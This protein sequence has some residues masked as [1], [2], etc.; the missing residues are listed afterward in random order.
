MQPE[1]LF[2]RVFLIILLILAGGYTP[3]VEAE[4]SASLRYQ[5]DFEDGDYT[6][7]DGSDGLTW[8]L[9]SGGAS[10]DEIG[11]SYWL[12]VDRGLSLI[13]TDQRMASDEYTLRL[14]ASL[15]W[16]AP[17]RIVVLYKDENNYY[18]VGLGSQPGVYRKWNGVEVQLKDDPEDLIRLPHGRDV[19]GAFKVYVRNDGQS[20][21]LQVDKAGD[22]V[23]YD[24]QVNDNDP[25][26]AAMFTNTGVG[27]MSGGDD[28]NP[29]WFYADNLALYDGLVTNPYTPVTYYVDQNHTQADDANPGTESLPLRTIQKA[30]DTVWAGDTVIVKSGTYPERITFASGTRGAPGQVITFRAEPRRSVTMWGFYTRYAHYLRMEGFNI[31]SDPSLT[32]WTELN[33]VFIDSDH[34]EVVDNYLYNLKSTAISGTSQGALIQNN[35]IYHSQA[36]LAVSGEGWLVEGNEVERLYD[37]GDG[38]CDYSR[39][40]GDD[41]ALRDN[42]FHGTQF[43]EI[44]S[45]H[46]DC[47]QTF[48]NNGEYAHHVTFEG[49][50]CYD[51][52][53][54]FMGEAAYY[55]N[56]SDLIFRNNIFAHGGAWG[57]SVHQIQ[58]VTAVHNVFADIQYHGIGF[59]DGASGLVYNNIFYNAGSNYWASDGGTVSGSHNLL[60]QTDGSLDPADFPDDLVNLDPRFTD[61]AS[62]DYHLLPGSPAIDTGLNLG[63]T[64]DLDGDLRPQ[65]G[66]YDIGADEFVPALVLHGAA[67]DG[68]IHLSWSVNISLPITATWQIDYEG[69]PGNPPPPIGGLEGVLRE[70]DLSGLT[71][72]TWYT[73]TLQAM[74]ASSPPLTDTIQLMPTDHLAYLPAAWK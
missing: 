38:D 18:S 55:G 21:L 68:T 4:G 33:G 39:F 51:F 11:G 70:Y 45:A 53:Q 72:Y 7:A 16:S 22:G 74:A 31:T 24:L 66:G 52:H 60:Y 25:A 67:G 8:R 69:P 58:N 13:V 47:F 64:S 57:M 15:T 28:P 20:I 62:D 54:G 59:R 17:G 26:A 65:G 48:D 10:V 63:V 19:T 5:D 56:I 73:V 2:F 50:V 9:V 1:K 34:V 37:Y 42:Y 71:N 27:L 29:P 12:G 32:G 49:N 61:P 30:A 43:N 14:D 41:H 36:G 23:D 46:V 6:Q 35:H 44:G 3:S 40:F